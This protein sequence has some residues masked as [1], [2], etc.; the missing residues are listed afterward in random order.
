MLDEGQHGCTNIPFLHTV[1]QPEVAKDIDDVLGAL[2]E[3]SLP[4]LY[5]VG[6]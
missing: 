4:T 6:A 2:P 3:A 5:T 1:V